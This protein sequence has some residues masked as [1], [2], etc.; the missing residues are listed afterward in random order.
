MRFY[1]YVLRRPDGT[2]FYVGKGCGERYRWCG[3]AHAQR[4][5]QEI[6]D[7]GQRIGVDRIPAA[8]EEAAFAEEKRLI[9][10]YGRIYL[11][12]GTLCNFTDGG[13]GFG[14]V[15]R[16]IKCANCGEGAVQHRPYGK[17]CSPL[18][19]Q[20]AW[21]RRKFGKPPGGVVAKEMRSRRTSKASR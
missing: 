3:N 13:E 17:Y 9:A 5:A 15:V 21:W 16:T 8:T 20:E 2:P 10:L 4:V 1:T 12:T 19:R 14:E 18:C 6:I 7:S 11:G